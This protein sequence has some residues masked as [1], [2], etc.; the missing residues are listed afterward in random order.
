MS[1]VNI[2]VNTLP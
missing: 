2:Q 1:G